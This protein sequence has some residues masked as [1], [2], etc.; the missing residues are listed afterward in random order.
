[1]VAKLAVVVQFG[2]GQTRHLSQR[3]GLD[4]PSVDLHPLARTR[5]G[6]LLRRVGAVAHVKPYGSVHNSRPGILAAGVNLGTSF[7]H[8]SPQVIVSREYSVS[9]K[10]SYESRDYSKEN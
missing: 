5:K 4:R 9:A 1:M 6:S 3:V 10:S 8:R 2:L 7:Q